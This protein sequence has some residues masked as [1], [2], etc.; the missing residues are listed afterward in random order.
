MTDTKAQHHKHRL[1]LCDLHSSQLQVRVILLTSFFTM[2]ELS[3]G[4]WQIWK[5]LLDLHPNYNYIKLVLKLVSDLFFMLFSSLSSLL[6]LL[7]FLQ[8]Y[9]SLLPSLQPE[10]IL[11][12]LLSVPTLS[13]VLLSHMYLSLDIFLASWGLRE[14]PQKDVIK[15]LMICVPLPSDK[16]LIIFIHISQ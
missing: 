4:R 13:F 5:D 12:V 9:I 10:L 1:A 16:N 14:P 11:H 3:S 2:V 15:D 8:D 7:L 6:L